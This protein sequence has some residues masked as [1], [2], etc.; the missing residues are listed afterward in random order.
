MNAYVCV[1]HA[2]ATN[3]PRFMIRFVQAGS[4]KEGGVI[5]EESCN[6]EKPIENGLEIGRRTFLQAAALVA[7][8]IVPSWVFGGEGPTAPSQR[9]TVGLIG[10][11]AL[12][13]ATCAARRRS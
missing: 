6:A 11:G 1:P 4:G 3:E 9:I 5:F 13:M 12:A 7:P 2:A 10:H 8:W